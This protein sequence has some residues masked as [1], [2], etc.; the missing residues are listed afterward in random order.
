MRVS[1]E[2]TETPTV[3]EIKARRVK[4]FLIN[5]GIVVLAAAVLWALGGADVQFL[6]PLPVL[7]LVG[8][9]LVFAVW[10]TIAYYIDKRNHLG[11]AA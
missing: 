4:W 5:S 9:I 2:L 8:G 7:L 1:D 10:E 6:L 3:S 11:R